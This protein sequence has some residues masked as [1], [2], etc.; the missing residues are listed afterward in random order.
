V[1]EI[2][3]TELNYWQNTIN[4]L[5]AKHNT[6]LE[7]LQKEVT[8]QAWRKIKDNHKALQI[9]SSLRKL[10]PF[11]G[12]NCKDAVDFEWPT[13]DDIAGLGSSLDSLEL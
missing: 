10:E 1:L 5:H 11:G 2:L 7:N 12:K 9:S 3:E 13:A 6:D 8:V 4:G